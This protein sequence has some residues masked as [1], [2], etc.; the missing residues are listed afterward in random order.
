MTKG[1][2]HTKNHTKTGGINPYRKTG[3]IEYFAIIDKE[4]G[5]MRFGGFIPSIN[6]KNIIIIARKGDTRIKGKNRIRITIGSCVRVIEE[7]DISS[8]GADK[9]SIV[10]VCTPSDKAQAEKEG[11]LTFQVE[12]GSFTT[13]IRSSSYVY[14]SAVAAATASYEFAVVADDIDIND[15]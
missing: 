1:S 10:N 2:T 6:K 9:F 15:I 14:S 12:E 13:D 3:D 4:Y 11:H 8:S 7:H 5:D